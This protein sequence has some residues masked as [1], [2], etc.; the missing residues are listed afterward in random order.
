MKTKKLIPRGTSIFVVAILLSINALRLGDVCSP[1]DV[2]CTSNC[3]RVGGLTVSLK[4]L[5]G[6]KEV[7]T[8]MPVTIKESPNEL[9]TCDS[10]GMPV[11]FYQI[12]N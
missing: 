11:E 2:E 3:M 9:I 10:R 4:A 12:C 7:I 1:H 8:C 6:S 5:A